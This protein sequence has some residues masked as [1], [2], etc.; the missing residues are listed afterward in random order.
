MAGEAFCWVG[1]LGV[2]FLEGVSSLAVV[3]VDGQET[4][5][6]DIRGAISR[7]IPISFYYT[8]PKSFFCDPQKQ[9][10]AQTVYPA[11]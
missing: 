4:V 7:S 11:R 2:R 9:S 1:S 10:R 8:Y 3:A 5:G 6:A